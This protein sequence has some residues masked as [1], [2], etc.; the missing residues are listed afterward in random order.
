MKFLAKITL[1][2]LIFIL[3]RVSPVFAEL[4]RFEAK[5]KE[6]KINQTGDKKPELTLRQFL[7]EY[8]ANLLER[9]KSKFFYEFYW[10]PYPPKEEFYIYDWR[11]RESENEWAKGEIRKDAMEIFLYSAEKFL[12]RIQWF[13]ELERMYGGLSSVE[14]ETNSGGRTDVRLPSTKRP[15]DNID[16][17]IRTL[18]KEIAHLEKIDDPSVQ[19][20]KLEL[21]ENIETLKRNREKNRKFYAKFRIISSGSIAEDINSYRLNITPELKL[22]FWGFDSAI[23]YELPFDIQMKSFAGNNAL[24]FNMQKRLF[25]VNWWANYYTQK[26][27]RFNIVELGGEKSVRGYN[28][29]VNQGLIDFGDDMNK[30]SLSAETVLYKKYSVGLNGNYDW[31]NNSS[32]ANFFLKFK[33]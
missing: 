31:K 3:I 6:E 9:K 32:G 5:P 21:K 25:G 22:N 19:S 10:N 20:K 1:I 28:L 26:E 8:D 15:V 2:A 7:L 23:S 13:K 12:G 33:F 14:V 18:E 11:T 4:P 24:K 29:R 30:T 17:A 27:G 16:L